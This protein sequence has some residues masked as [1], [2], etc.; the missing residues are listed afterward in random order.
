MIQN[1][2]LFAIVVFVVSLYAALAVGMLYHAYRENRA[3][4]EA[5]ER[6]GWPESRPS[7]LKNYDADHQH[8]L[9]S[10]DPEFWLNKEVKK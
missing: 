1:G 5:I 4:R 6:L 8:R 9:R 10:D 7:F 3:R 2:T